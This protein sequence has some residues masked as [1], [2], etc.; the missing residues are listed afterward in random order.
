[1]IL[2]INTNFPKQPPENECGNKEY[3]RYLFY[4]ENK[5]G[6]TK[7]EFIN[8]R[9]SQMLYRLLEGNGKAVY[10]IGVDDNGLIYSL[11]DNKI[12]ETIKYIKLI[13]YKIGANI[14]TIRIYN[15]RVCTIRIFLNKEILENK[16]KNMGLY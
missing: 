5:R 7:N 13:S 14:K 12:E 4:N 8:K 2:H 6:G 16:L 1:M 15:N 11:N 10:L 9:A 3:K